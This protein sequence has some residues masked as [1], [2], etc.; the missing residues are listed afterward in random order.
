MPAPGFHPLSLRTALS[1]E[2]RGPEAPNRTLQHPRGRRKGV[3]R[4]EAIIRNESRDPCLSGN[5]SDQMA[6]RLCR[7]PGEPSSVNMKDSRALR[8]IGRPAPPPATP[9]TVSE[10]NVTPS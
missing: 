9:P 4:R 7:T 8:S 5:M 10:S 2:Y 1:A 3:L 6:E